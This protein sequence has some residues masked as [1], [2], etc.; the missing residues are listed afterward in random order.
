[1]GTKPR[2]LTTAAIIAEQRWAYERRVERMTYRAMRDL[3]VLPVEQGGLGRDV[4]EATLMRRANDYLKLSTE[5]E[6]ETRTVA[7]GREL[8]ALDRQERAIY[9]MLDIVDRPATMLK[10]AQLGLDPASPDAIVLRDDKTILVA[11]AQLRATSES[12][13]KLLGLDAPLEVGVTVTTATD[14]ALADLAAQ[15]GKPAPTPERQDHE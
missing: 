4:S 11:L 13:R 9:P 10:A 12:R 1:M 3:V 6:T 14:K 8:E 5:L 7:R 2:E 15:L